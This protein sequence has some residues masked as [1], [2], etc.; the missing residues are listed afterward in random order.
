MTTRYGCPPARAWC[1]G[2]PGTRRCRPG[3]RC[4]GVGFEYVENA[5]RNG[6]ALRPHRLAG[7]AQS[8][9]ELRNHAG[10]R[11]FERSKRTCEASSP[12]SLRRKPRGRL[13][14]DVQPQGP[15]IRPA[16]PRRPEHGRNRATACLRGAGAGARG[17]AGVVG[18]ASRRRERAVARRRGATGTAAGATGTVT[19]SV[20]TCRDRTRS[21][22]SCSWS[23][24]PGASITTGGGPPGSRRSH[25]RRHDGLHDVGRCRARSN[26]PR[27]PG[28]PARP[29][30]VIVFPGLLS[31]NGGEMNGYNCVSL[32][33]DLT[34]CAVRPQFAAAY[35]YADPLRGGRPLLHVDVRPHLP[36][37]PVYHG[38]RVLR[39]RR[40]QDDHRH[41]RQLLR[42]RTRVS[43]RF[44]IE[45]LTEA[46]IK[47]I[48]RLEEN[49][50]AA[51]GQLSKIAAYFGTTRTCINIKVLPISSR[52][53]A[54]AGSTTPTRA[55]G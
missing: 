17:R 49:I 6:R 44:P 55:H 18:L 28:D 50:T 10:Q 4:R 45:D 12:P 31:I 47:R 21:S 20:V 52:R 1:S 3:S 25:R 42:R 33:E 48:M 2:T 51:P 8:R 46:D 53:P 38:C 35:A 41:R 40:Q 19:T 32:G 7:P 11:R 23:R 36:R 9:V 29:R 13:R 15:L 26:S 43:Q 27:P 16:G 39:D 34:G 54:S 37:T 22:T 30:Q 24:R 5:R 14:P